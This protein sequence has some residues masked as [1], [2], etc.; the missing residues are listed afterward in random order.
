MERD[1]IVLQHITEQLKTALNKIDTL[2]ER[3]S[4]T[5]GEMLLLQRILLA[6]M[7]ALFGL[8][9]PLT[10]ELLQPGRAGSIIDA[11]APSAPVPPIQRQRSTP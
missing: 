3:I 7:V 8:S 9:N 6:A 11:P 5:K 1:D 2:E 4:Q 10:Q